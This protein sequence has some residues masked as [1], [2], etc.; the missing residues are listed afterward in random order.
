MI[1]IGIDILRAAIIGALFFYLRS[2]QGKERFRLGKGWVLI[3]I[4]VGLFF[5]GSLL[6]ITDNF[7]GLS[8]YVI[9]GKTKYEDFLEEVV[10]YFFGFIFVAIGF[11]KWM[12]AIVALRQEKIALKKSQEELR[13]KIEELTAELNAVR[14]EL[15]QNKTRLREGHVS[16]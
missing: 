6:D 10:G 13:L 9:I 16:S 4:G 8:K 15:E 1:E 12:P 14:L 3:L 5:F 7:P 11:W 2:A